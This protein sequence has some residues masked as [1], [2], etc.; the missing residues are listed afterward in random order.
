MHPYRFVYVP[1]QRRHPERSVPVFGTRSR[2]TPKVAILRMPLAPF[3]PHAPEPGLSY[4]KGS[5][6]MGEIKTFGVLRL[7]AS[8]KTRGAPLRMTILWGMKASG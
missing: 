6:I 4:W 5:N 7:R 1:P 3:L 8:Q 2:R